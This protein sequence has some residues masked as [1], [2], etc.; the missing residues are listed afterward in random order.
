MH[1]KLTIHTCIIKEREREKTRKAMRGETTKGDKENNLEAQGDIPRFYLNDL[2]AF[3]H[4]S[5][6]WVSDF[7]SKN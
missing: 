1:K 7:S 4:F 6:L 5:S 3:A 2:V